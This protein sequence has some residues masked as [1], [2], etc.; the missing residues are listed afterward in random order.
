MLFVLAV[1]LL[2]AALL[3]LG[4]EVRIALTQLDHHP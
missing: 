1:A 4:R 3:Y 2:G